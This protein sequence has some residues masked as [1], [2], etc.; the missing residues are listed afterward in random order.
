M[1]RLLDWP[2]GLGRIAYQRLTGPRSV[3]SAATESITG[4]VQTVASA[5]GVWRYQISL[6]PLRGGKTRHYR[7]MVTALHGGANAVRVPFNDPDVMTFREA[8]VSGIPDTKRFPTVNWS[9]GL[10]WSNGEPWQLSRPMVRVAQD[11]AVGDTIIDLEDEFW[12][13]TIEAGWLGF[14]PFH[15]GKYEITEVIAPGQ[16]RIW[17]PLR[18]GL[19]GYLRYSADF[20]AAD[21][22]D[23]AV[24]CERNSDGY[25]QNSSGEW[26]LFAPNVARITDLGLLIEQEATNFI[27]NNSMQ[28]A[29]AGTPGTRPTNWPSISLAGLTQTVVGVGTELGVN[30]IDLR[31]NGTASGGTLQIPLEATTQIAAVQGQSWRNSAFLK[32]VSGSFN[33]IAS[34]RLRLSE[35]NAAGVVLTNGDFIISNPTATLTRFSQPYT[36]V[37][38]TTAFVR[39]AVMFVATIGAAID[40]TIRIGWPQL[41]RDSVTSPIRTTT[42]AVTREADVISLPVAGLHKLTATFDDDTTQEIVNPTNLTAALLDRT[43]IKQV[44]GLTGRTYAHLS[45]VVA[46]RLESEAAGT[47]QRGIMAAEGNILTMVEVEDQDVRDYFAD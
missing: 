36:T 16:Y 38:P 33:G 23:G 45:P 31:F 9:N 6:Q 5:F 44:A 43:L 18:K 22:P 2:V 40:F 1:A 32:L 12:G 20:V 13:H 35:C 19:L 46:M 25:A 11:A 4:F 47:V 24:S 7:K 34:S 8:G 37:N 15:F 29:V 21:Y 42:T 30:Y 39:P 3:G 17:P 10:P 28:G 14:M 27:R 41:E 26:E